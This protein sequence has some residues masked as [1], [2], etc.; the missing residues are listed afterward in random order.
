MIIKEIMSDMNDKMSSQ[1]FNG[2][3]KQGWIHGQYQSRTGGQGR[4]CAFSHF[5]TRLPRT[6]QPTNQPTNGRTDGQSLL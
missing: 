1:F 5:P 4:K 6:N 3:T 2:W